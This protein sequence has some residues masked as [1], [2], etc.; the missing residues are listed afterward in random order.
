MDFFNYIIEKKIVLIIISL[1]INC[2]LLSV[3]GFLLWNLY[4]YECDCNNMDLLTSEMIENEVNEKYYVD[5]KGS[6]KNP[7]VYEVNKTNIINDVIKLAGGFTK[8]AYTK[9]INLSKKVSNELVI[10]VYSNSEYKKLT[11]ENTNEKETITYECVCPEYE[12]TDC[13][14]NGSSEIITDND[15]LEN[16]STNVDSKDN[17]NEEEVKDTSNEIKLININTASIE[18]LMTLS[19]I[20]EAKAKSIIEYRNKTKFYSIEDIK[21]VSGIGDSAFEKIKDSITV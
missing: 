8:T 13:I 17:Q 19:G 4:T 10:Y 11:E 1:I 5:I 18:E 20:G 16:N 9:N 6:V 7:G 21:N 14:N 2:L 12:I 3:S 15:E